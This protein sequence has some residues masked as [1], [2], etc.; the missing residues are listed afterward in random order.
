MC[1][2]KCQAVEMVT[3]SSPAGEPLPSCLRFHS[4]LMRRCCSVSQIKSNGIFTATTFS[5]NQ[6][7][8]TDTDCL[9]T[10]RCAPTFLW[11]QMILSPYH[12]PL[13]PTL[14]PSVAPSSS[15][16]LPTLRRTRPRIT[17]AT[18]SLCR[19]SAKCATPATRTP[20]SAPSESVGSCRRQSYSADS[21]FRQL[22]GE[23][24]LVV[25]LSFSFSLS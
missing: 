25:L 21:V 23:L 16:N 12:L 9:K 8:N 2:A 7:K 4:L 24:F 1:E 13:S 18:T 19:A 17:A 14:S 3:F 6:S 10:C 20:T 22:E 15:S 5:F 11:S